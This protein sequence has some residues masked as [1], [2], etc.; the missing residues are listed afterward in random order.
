MQKEIDY[1]TDLAPRAHK[2]WKYLTQEWLSLREEKTR[3]SR[4]KTVA[5][6]KALS[7][8][9]FVDERWNGTDVNLYRMKRARI[10]GKNAVQLTGDVVRTLA[11][12]K[13]E[14]GL[15]EAANSNV[16]TDIP[17]DLESSTRM[18]IGRVT[19]HCDESGKTLEQRVD[20]RTKEF[21]RA[22][23]GENWLNFINSN[24]AKS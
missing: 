22:I 8:R 18:L 6:W 10:A 16:E 17:L 9:G 5:S 4:G 2:I 20:E 14:M 24:E 3:K 1:F 13:Y 11:Y 7:E 15:K 21:A 23:H 19:K 12:S